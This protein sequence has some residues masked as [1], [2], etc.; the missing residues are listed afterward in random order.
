MKKG[1]F[2]LLFICFSNQL[3]AQSNWKNFWEL[4]ISHKK[5]VLLHP[6]RAKKASEISF[7]ANKVSDS[8]AKTD[9]LDKDKAG[10]QVDAFRH[11]YWMAR[12]RQEIGKCA[13][14][15]LGKAHEKDNYLTFKKN[16]MEN[17]IVP[18][19]ASKEMDLFNNKVG[20]LFTKKGV[21]TNQKKLTHEIVAAILKGDLKIIKK[22]SIGNYVTCNGELI[23]SEELLHAWKNNKCLISSN[24]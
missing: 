22:D 4:S 24:K 10:G 12:L 3:C 1:F 13:A 9:L 5:W 20:L 14:Y 8:I 19:N 11:A 15:S 16:K 21:V 17:G 7:E 2:I 6:F 23:A 18:D